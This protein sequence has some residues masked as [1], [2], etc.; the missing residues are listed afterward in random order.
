MDRWK[1][2]EDVTRTWFGV[3]TALATSWSLSAESRMV[4][5]RQVH[6]ALLHSHSSS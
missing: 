2:D 4:Q 5:I 1:A 6:E 3:E